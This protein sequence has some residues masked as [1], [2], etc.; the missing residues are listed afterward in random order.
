[1]QEK[2]NFYITTTLPY[3][4]DEPHIGF[5]LEVVL[6]DALAREERLSG[7]RVFFNCGTDEHGQKIYL[8]AKSENRDIKE[9]V[10][11][12]AGK[13]NDLKKSLNLSYDVF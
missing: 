2:K 8:R 10:D 12:Y 5:A 6:A 3:V 11:F 9:Y 4:N 7:R 1:M 13:F